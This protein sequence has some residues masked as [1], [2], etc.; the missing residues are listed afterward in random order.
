MIKGRQ[1]GKIT[2]EGNERSRSLERSRGH[3]GR[4]VVVEHELR[5][6]MLNL[7]KSSSNDHRSTANDSSSALSTFSTSLIAVSVVVVVCGLVLMLLTVVNLVRRTFL[8]RQLYL[9]C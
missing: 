8:S 7:N 4:S 6:S 2:S 9:T 1:G 3:E 5:L